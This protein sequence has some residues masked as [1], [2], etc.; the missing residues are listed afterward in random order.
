MTLPTDSGADASALARDAS[1]ALDAGE[2]VRA[3]A[4][5]SQ[6]LALRPDVEAWR[7]G[8]ATA[9]AFLARYEEALADV[10]TALAND[11]GSLRLRLERGHALRAAG[12]SSESEAV[13]RAVLDEHADQVEALANLGMLLRQE[14]RHAEAVQALERAAALRP[15][16]NEVL[17][18]LGITRLHAGDP[19][20]AT[21]DLDQAMAANPWN[22]N[23][24]A[25]RYSAA[26]AMGDFAAASRLLPMEGTVAVYDDLLSAAEAQGLLQVV[27]NH[28]SLV[29]ERTGNT[30]RGGAHTGN[31]LDEPHPRVAALAA[32][33]DAVLGQYL[34]ALRKDPGHPY[35]AWRP[36]RWRLE[37]WSVVLKS[38]GY[39]EPHIHPDGWVSGVCY[40]AVPEEIDTARDAAGWLE[41]GRPPVAHRPASGLPVRT[42]Q[43]RPGRLV[44][45]PS[46]AWHRTLPFHSDRQRV[47]VAF[48]MRPMA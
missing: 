46:S 47:C 32:R 3:E 41:I 15:A 37:I 29:W 16:D 10:E 44:L 45:F 2:T 9:R 19:A 26:C 23:T 30:T 39:Q 6:A 13:Y 4:L 34:A 22:R 7:L 40:L 12:R 42:V 38:G 24:L 5:F 31:L 14:A 25:H 8:R 27:E 48:D 20:G 17:T 1:Q 28:P 33:L 21:R 36:D 18:A 43:P 35:L 11:P